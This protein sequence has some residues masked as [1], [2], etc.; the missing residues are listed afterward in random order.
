MVLQTEERAGAFFVEE[1]L[2][3]LKPDGSYIVLEHPIEHERAEEEGWMSS[4]TFGQRGSL[5]KGPDGNGAP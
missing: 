5:A 4:G 2:E 3:L 1:H